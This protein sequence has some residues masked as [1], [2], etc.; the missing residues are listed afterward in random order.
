MEGI[1][2]ASHFLSLILFWGIFITFVAVRYFFAAIFYKRGNLSTKDKNAVSREGKINFI[3][4]RFIVMPLYLVMLFFYTINPPWMKVFTPQ[5][6]FWGFMAGG[7]T[8]L[9]GIA[10]LIAV[11]LALGRE[12]AANLQ[13]RK[14]HKLIKTGIYS[15]IRHPMYSALFLI[16]AGLAVV[17]SNYLI[18]V[19]TIFAEASIIIRIPKEEQMLI[20]EFGN[21]YK[22]YMKKT[23]A[24]VPR[25]F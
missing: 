20:A 12:W 25:F 14:G 7:V 15:A 23:G 21:E 22:K 1:T 17:S 11:H 9:C 19:L 24:F 6:P 18:M 16:Q 8:G 2:M 13:L 3:F 5:L 10:L 4:R